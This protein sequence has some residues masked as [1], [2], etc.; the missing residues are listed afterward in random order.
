MNRQPWA[1]RT[2]HKTRR[3]RPANSNATSLRNFRQRT[4]VLGSRAAQ[5]KTI[6]G[7]CTILRLVVGLLAGLLPGFT[8]AGSAPLLG[9]LGQWPTSPPI[10]SGRASFY[11]ASF[12]GRKTASGERFHHET[13]SAASNRFPLGTLV[14]VRRQT[15]AHCVVVK[16]NDRMG[17]RSRLIDLSRQAAVR[18]GMIDAGVTEVDVVPLPKAL[19]GHEHACKLAFSPPIQLHVDSPP[20]AEDKR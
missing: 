11:G 3:N 17:H 18:L 5:C 12:S 7:S 19:V 13:I 6:V 16:I 10:V 20:V 15:S 14:A 2:R 9:A 8:A 4:S 1:A